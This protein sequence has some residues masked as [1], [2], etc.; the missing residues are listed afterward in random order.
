MENSFLSTDEIEQKSNFISACRNE[1]HSR[2]PVWFMRQAGRSLPEYKRIRGPGSILDAVSD[3]Y[4]FFILIINQGG[5]K[6]IF[7]TPLN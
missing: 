4:I 1:E 5:I 2:V 3:S 7:N 6:I